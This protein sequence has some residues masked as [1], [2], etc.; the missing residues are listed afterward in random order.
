V[1]SVGRGP[2]AVSPRVPG[3]RARRR[4]KTKSSKALP[5]LFSSAFPASARDSSRPTSQCS[6]LPAARAL[7]VRKRQALRGWPDLQMVCTELHPSAAN[8]LL[9]PLEKWY[10]AARAQ[11]ALPPGARGPPACRGNVQEAHPSPAV[12][13]AAVSSPRARRPR[14]AWTCMRCIVSRCTS[15]PAGMDAQSWV[16]SSVETHTNH[17]THSRIKSRFKCSGR[18]GEHGLPARME[19]A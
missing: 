14:P 17:D 12:E 6:H 7:R 3:R 8:T 11:C 2:R 9:M 5:V 16:I 15:R 1:R 18:P 10:A 4:W 19:R 13:A